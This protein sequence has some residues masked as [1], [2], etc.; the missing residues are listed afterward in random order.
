MAEFNVITKFNI[1][2]KEPTA[3]ID[4]EYYRK[5]YIENEEII[6]KTGK[7]Y[8]IG[9]RFHVT[10]GEHGNVEYLS[11]GVKYLTAENIKNGFVDMSKIRYVSNAVH[12]RNSRASVNQGD[13]LISIKATLGQV[14]M[15]EE[16]LPPCNMN[17]DVAIIKPLFL[18]QRNS[19][20]AYLA[21]F[22]MSKFG[23]IQAQR[24]GSGGVQQ[25]ITLERLR[26][27][28]VPSFT[29]NLYSKIYKLVTDAYNSK[30]QSI[31]HFNQA[32]QVLLERLG[33]LDF[34]LAHSLCT[35]KGL[36]NSFYTSGRI[37]G[38]YHQ[39]RYDFIEAKISST[40]TV[41]SLCRINDGRFIP[42]KREYNYIELSNIGDFGN[43]TGQTTALFNNL[44]SRAR[45][46]VKK[47]QV[48]ISSIEG[49]L[50]SCAMIT[51]E[52]DG[53]IC[54][55]G[56]YIVESNKINTETLLILFKSP[57]IQTLMR[58]RC[59]G[60]ILT[61]ISKGALEQMPLPEIDKNIQYIISDEVQK[62]IKLR[63]QFRESLN[64]AIKAVEI[65]IEKNENCALSFIDS[66][67]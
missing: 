29:P 54:S 48:I 56:F 35:V 65:A 10:D 9:Q 2:S 25:M 64:V 52:N 11:S 23:F 20:N 59:S 6:K 17:R 7:T 27:F 3:R 34:S 28:V 5:H 55:T 58:R 49:S 60:T 36:M 14:A 19:E 43:I 26:N 24:G 45:R 37:D 44:P 32:E 18:N 47:G 46:L 39:E 40:H 21:A 22:L 33:F 4:S 62:S 57:P 61:A 42:E 15:A 66:V 8:K 31:I 30:N 1:M 13:I 51:D 53:S 50:S 12:T 63:H 16:W 67:S 41:K 38:E